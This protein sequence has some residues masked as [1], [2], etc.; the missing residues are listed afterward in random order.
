MALGPAALLSAGLLLLL[1]H[2]AFPDKGPEF[3]PIRLTVE[4]DL[5]N[6]SP[7]SYSCSMVKD[8]VLLGAMKRLKEAQPGFNFTVTEHPDFGPFLESVNGVAGDEQEHTYWELLSE[9]S[10]E[11]TRLDVGVGCYIPKSDEHIILRFNT[12]TPENHE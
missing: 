3:H 9:S 6:L 11:Y 7:E 2:G 5:S 10:G 1:A 4:N 8:G 12:W